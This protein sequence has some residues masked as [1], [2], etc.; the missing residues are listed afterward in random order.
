VGENT[1]GKIVSGA[2]EMK[3]RRCVR[4]DAKLADEAAKL[5][6][7]GSRTEAVDT[8]LRRVVGLESFE[9]ASKKYGGKPK[10]E[11]CDR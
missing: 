10:L 8:A 9:R 1:A 11:R 3:K 6:G 5:L 7:A 4:V 2:N